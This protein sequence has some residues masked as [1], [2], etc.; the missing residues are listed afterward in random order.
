VKVVP[1]TIAPFEQLIE[2]ILHGEWSNHYPTSTSLA[3]DGSFLPL[4]ED[5]VGPFKP[6]R[7]LT[8]PDRKVRGVD[9]SATYDVRVYYDLGG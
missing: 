6:R 7:R 1:M 2:R 4:S 3:I 8:V 9:E 5:V